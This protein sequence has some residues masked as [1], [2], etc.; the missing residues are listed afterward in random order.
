MT[1]PTITKTWLVGLA[2]VLAGSFVAGIATVVWLAH[3]INVTGNGANYVPDNLFWTTVAFWW[4]TGVVVVAGIL[5]QMA[6]WIGAV[7]NSHRL[8]DKTWFN[9]LLWIG[10]I[11]ILTSPLFGLGAMVWWGVTIAYM[12][13]APD[14]MTVQQLPTAT[15]VASPTKLAPTS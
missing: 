7:V 11:G 2:V 12:I 3:V 14:G 13:A 5:V 9:L 15:P 10:A 1:K 4:G 6:A 8:V